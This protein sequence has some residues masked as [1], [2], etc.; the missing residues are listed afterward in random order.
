MKVKHICNIQKKQFIFWIIV[1][2]FWVMMKA[3]EEQYK[4][5]EVRLQN[6]NC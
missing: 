6:S 5:N 1:V 4:N 3:D 2:K